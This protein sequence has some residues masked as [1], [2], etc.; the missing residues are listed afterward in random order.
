M[1][2]FDTRSRV[3]VSSFIIQGTIIGCVFA[4]GIF[5]KILEDEFGWSRTVLSASSSIAFLVMGLFAILGGRI[6]DRY[7]PRWVLSA[8]GLIT[9]LGYILLAG[10]QQPWQLVLIYGLMIG[11]GLATHDVVTLSTVASWF[12][13]RRGVMTGIVKTGTATGQI[14]VPPLVAT[15]IVLVDWRSALWVVGLVSGL[16]LIASAQG[17]RRPARRTG[18]DGQSSTAESTGL[19]VNEAKS[20]RAFWTFCA[21]Q[22][23]FLPSL[24]TIPL[25]VVV[26]ASDMGM[27]KAHVAA[28]LSTIGGCSILGRLLLGFMLDRLGGRLAMLLSLVPLCLSLCSLF[29]IEEPLYLFLFALVYGF[30]HGGL[31]TV[32]SPTVA[33]YFGMRSH[34]S[35]F[36][37]IVFFGTLGGAAGPILAGWIF[38]TRG[39]YDMAFATLALLALVAILLAASLGRPTQQYT[40]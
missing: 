4:Y 7:G 3:V 13:K 32:V 6:N 11:I 9:G 35:L 24:I 33:E 22:F 26:H 37:I 28:L 16:V 29:F 20:T 2:T 8:S 25:H 34:G 36:G 15:L 38:D 40:A 27:H 14:L 1:F 12:E 31:F 39:S 30:G 21:I 10:I 5:F 19:S 23:C 17:M 18:S